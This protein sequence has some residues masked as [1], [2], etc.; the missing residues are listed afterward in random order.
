MHQDGGIVADMKGGCKRCKPLRYA[1]ALSADLSRALLPGKTDLQIAL[2]AA[3]GFRRGLLRIAAEIDL[4][5]AGIPL[6]DGQRRY[7][8]PLKLRKSAL[9]PAVIKLSVSAFR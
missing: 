2:Q 6:G 3:T 5:E 9:T 1:N 8:N 4:G 7:R